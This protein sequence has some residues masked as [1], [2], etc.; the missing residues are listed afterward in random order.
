M[1]KQDGIIKSNDENV[2]EQVNGGIEQE[3]GILEVKAVSSAAIN[4]KNTPG[5]NEDIV[6]W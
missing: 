5:G 6:K 1:K 2:L 4:Q 3:E